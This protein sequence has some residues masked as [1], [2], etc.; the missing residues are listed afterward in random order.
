MVV[1]FQFWLTRRLSK[2]PAMLMMALASIFYLVG[3]GM[4]GVVS[5]IWLFALGMA[6]L[7]IGEM[8]AVPTSQGLVAKLAPEDMRGRYMAV[9]S[10]AWTIPFAVGTY[11][12]GLIM[13]NTRPAWVWYA[14]AIICTF[15][16]MGYIWLYGRAKERLQEGPVEPEQPEPSPA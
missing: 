5:G 13:D 9:A 8:V 6:V 3:F 10:L 2:Y 14:A 11:L 12:A 16:F 7:T 1:F 4:F 15:T